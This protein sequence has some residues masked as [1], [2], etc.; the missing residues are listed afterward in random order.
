MSERF[1]EA[2]VAA[3]IAEY[4]AEAA[5]EEAIADALRVHAEDHERRADL[6]RSQNR[7]LL[8]LVNS[9]ARR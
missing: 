9:E 1:D 2:K 4:E 5:A 3:R 6:C 8:E 7:A